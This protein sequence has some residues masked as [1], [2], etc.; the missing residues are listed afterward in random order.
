MADNTEIIAA[1]AAI[2][3]SHSNNEMTDMPVWWVIDPRR[4]TKNIHAQIASMVYGPFWSR[5]NALE[6]LEYKRHWYGK[7]PIVYCTPAK[8]DLRELY[9]LSKSLKMEAGNG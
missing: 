8:G 4:L 9:R 2:A 7:R 6:H 5:E 3:G 1:V